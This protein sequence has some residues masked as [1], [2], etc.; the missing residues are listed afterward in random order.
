M[1][2]ERVLVT[3]A[4]GF[5]GS[6][7][8]TRLLAEGREV[9]GIDCLT[10][11][12]DP[13]L[14]RQNIAESLL[15]DRFTF[16]QE[17]LLETDLPRWLD[18]CGV[19]FHQAAQAGVRASWGD[20]FSVYLHCNLAA[21]QRLLETVKQRE[22]IK[23]VYASSSSVYGMVKELPMRE[24]S[25]P[26]PHSPYG[27]TKLAAEQLIDLYR[28]NYGLRATALRYFT[29]YGP[30]QRPD[31]AFRIFTEASLAD[32]VIPIYGD[33]SQTRDFTFIDDI[34]E[35]NFRAAAYDG[36]EYVFNVGGGSRVTLKE[37]LL[38]LEQALGKSLRLD[39]QESCKG[40]VQ[41]T[42]A[43]CSLIE[44]ELG[45]KP[46]IKLATGLKREVAWCRERGQGL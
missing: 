13:E 14:K 45:F 11:Y 32:Q 9:V 16:V 34:V 43:D 1:S 24:T 25:L 38:L 40:D 27:V 33:G 18:G 4:A 2:H 37:A 36:P 28:M 5:I 6:T 19:V 15:N 17:D 3:G 12:Y 30:R 22:E 41:D 21:T 29:V 35:A 26:R 23:L 46:Q 39:F 8:V 44:T 7:I 10:D 20:E 42:L 31:M